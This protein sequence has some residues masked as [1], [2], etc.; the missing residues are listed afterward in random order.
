MLSIISIRRAVFPSMSCLLSLLSL[1]ISLSTIPMYCDIFFGSV[2][3]WGGGRVD[4]WHALIHCWCESLSLLSGQVDYSLYSAAVFASF[5]WWPMCKCL[6]QINLVL[7]DA[8]GRDDS[9]RSYICAASAR[10]VSVHLGGLEIAS[11]VL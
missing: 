2:L 9:C 11:L 7:C 4:F 10:V 8:C 3:G 6:S 1:R 5:A